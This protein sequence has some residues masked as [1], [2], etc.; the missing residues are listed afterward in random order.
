VASQREIRRRI[1]AVRN[2][3]QITRAMLFVAAS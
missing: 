2:I 1:G 3:T